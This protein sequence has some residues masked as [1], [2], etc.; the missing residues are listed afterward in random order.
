MAED[1]DKTTDKD[2]DD[3][4]TKVRELVTEIR[5][6]MGTRHT[7]LQA[8][9]DGIETAREEEKVDFGKLRE[10][11]E[12]IKT[13]ADEREN[14]IREIE[15]RNLISLRKDPVQK[16]E[17]A[18]GVLGMMC[19]SHMAAAM[20]TELPER[21]SGEREQVEG[22]MREFH[23]RAT[24]D[25]TT[26]AGGYFIPT[27]LVM[28]IY[29]T[30]EEVSKLLSVVD[31]QSGVP[32]KGS[33]VTL[34]GRP[35][36][37]PARASSAT[38][39]T[40]SDPAFGQWDWDTAEGHI[41]FPVDNWML[42]LSPIQVGQRM[43][44]IVRDA[45]VGGLCDWLVNA[46]AT[47]SYN[48]ITGILE[49]AVKVVRMAGTTFASLSNE[50]L[51]KLMR[52]VLLRARRA[53]SFVAGPYVIDVLEDIGREGK[54]PLLKEKGDGSYRLKGKAFIEDE[55]MPD[56][57][58]SAADT[59]LLGFGDPKTWGV[60]LAGAGIQIASDSSYRFAYNQTA[61]RGVGHVDIVRKPGNTWAL[62]KTKAS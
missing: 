38:A 18:L 8:K 29:D 12:A 36:L 58:D 47:S 59:A 30:I 4:Q 34:T 1:K 16:R 31:F 45:Y 13:Q 44:N 35:T 28:D 7:D 15:Q 9:L 2:T 10:E 54:I 49:D 6:E 43:L 57:T 37:Q 48:S 5:E 27:V 62:L 22:Y 42:Q 39:M 23:E 51:R 20:R 50:D 32:T 26:T 40:Q 46:D 53:G 3:A 52:G 24:L 33:G 61:F 14:T 21:F 41:Y 17:Q 60:V 19:R 25:E 11:L 55:G 56:E